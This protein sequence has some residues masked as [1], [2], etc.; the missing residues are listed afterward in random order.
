[1]ADALTHENTCRILL[2]VNNNFNFLY[3]DFCGCETVMCQSTSSSVVMARVFE[4]RVTG[5]G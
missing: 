4:A 3:T 2:T 5:L 1:M